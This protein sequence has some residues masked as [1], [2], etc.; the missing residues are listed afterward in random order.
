MIDSIDRLKRVAPE[1]YAYHEHTHFFEPNE[2]TISR[3]VT[4]ANQVSA[5]WDISPEVMQVYN[6]CLV[7]EKERANHIPGVYNLEVRNIPQRTKEFL[8]SEFGDVSIAKCYFIAYSCRRSICKSTNN[9]VILTTC[10]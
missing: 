4:I 8:Y 9:N 2:R 6:D 1:S 3:V 10:S 5:D 7:F